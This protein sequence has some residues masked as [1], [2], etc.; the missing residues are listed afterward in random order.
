M[1]EEP[2]RILLVE[3]SPTH[4]AMVRHALEGVSGGVLC[5]VATSLAEARA[6]LQQQAFDLVLSDLTLPDGKGTE[7]LPDDPERVA[8]PLILLTVTTDRQTAIEAIKAGA[9]DYVVK[10]PEVL[11]GLPHTVERALRDWG[12]IVDR[13][14]AKEQATRFGR[15]I[16]ASPNEVYTFEAE[17]LRYVHVNRGALENLGY[18]LEEM[19]LLTPLDLKVDLDAAAFAEILGPLRSGSKQGVQFHS[20]HR[21]KD[22]TL[23]PVEVH[24]HFSADEAR[25]VFFAIVLDITE[26][27]WAEEALRISEER[28]RSV[29]ETAAAGMV[30]I[31]ADGRL[32]QANP[33]FCRYI[34]YSASQMIGRPVYELTHPDD[35]DRT[36]EYFRHLFSDQ[37]QIV[38]TEKRYLRKDGQVLW[39]HTS[40]ACVPGADGRP[41]YCVGLVQ[42]ITERKSMEE[43]LRKANAELDAFVYTVS[44]DLRTPLTPIIGYAQYLRSACEGRLESQELSF[45]EEIDKQGKAMVALLED[46]LAMARLGGVEAGAEPLV[47]EQV[48]QQV[49]ETQASQL[50][51]AGVQVV[52]GPLPKVRMSKSLAVQVLDNL[53]GNAIR[54]AGKAGS[55]V[56]IGGKRDGDRVRLFVQDHGPGV[57]EEEMDHIFEVFFRGKAW[58]GSKGTG[59]GL[60]TVQKIARLHNGMAWVEK[61][62]G[63]GATFWVELEDAQGESARGS[64]EG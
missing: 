46:L 51:M 55:P 36:R 56:E 42:D 35:R 53:I 4:A 12:Y 22:G 52:V 11:A 59:I 23:Y 39:G 32:V 49:L 30:V 27:K 24:L 33:A 13:R 37:R 34:G 47:L 15:L 60:A 6:T 2:T 17:S 41:A 38:N 18:T 3:D 43:R 50:A 26:R 45:L 8:F 7:L 1:A 25:P 58:K 10:S 44:H 63:G 48:V 40:V 57:P 20:R 62:P 21:R 5:T 9:V 16:D 14:R 64:V 29:F 61:T 28:F 19:R 54:Y 31:E